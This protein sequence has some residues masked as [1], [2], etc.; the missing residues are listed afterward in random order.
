MCYF[1]VLGKFVHQ[2]IVTW[3]WGVW[4]VGQHLWVCQMAMTSRS[5]KTA[6]GLFFS[7]NVSQIRVSMWMRW[8]VVLLTLKPVWRF[9]RRLV[10]G[11]VSSYFQEFCK[12]SWLSCRSTTGRVCGIFFYFEDR[13]GCSLFLLVRDGAREPD[14]VVNILEIFQGYHWKFFQESVVDFIWTSG[15]VIG[16]GSGILEFG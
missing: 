9:K 14:I 6:S 4:L 10:Q 7:M 15:W 12:N 3:R 16:F 13:G 8:S 1:L 2:G 11:N 5:K